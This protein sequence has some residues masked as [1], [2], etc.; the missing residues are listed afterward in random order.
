MQ[1]F[2]WPAGGKSIRG[3]ANKTGERGADRTMEGRLVGL[4]GRLV[5]PGGRQVDLQVACQGGS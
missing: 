5:N 3:E 4:L 2:R 1:V